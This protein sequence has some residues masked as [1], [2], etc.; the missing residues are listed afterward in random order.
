[1]KKLHIGHID[2]YALRYKG[3]QDYIYTLRS[4]IGRAIL[5]KPEYLAFLNLTGV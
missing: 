2:I 4:A 3:H 1:M 5:Q